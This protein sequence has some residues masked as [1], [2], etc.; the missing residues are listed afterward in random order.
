MLITFFSVCWILF[1]RFIHFIRFLFKKNPTVKYKIFIQKKI[2]CTDESF[3]VIATQYQRF[4]CPWLNGIKCGSDEVSNWFRFDVHFDSL[5]RGTNVIVCY[6]AW[7]RRHHEKSAIFA[8]TELIGFDLFDRGSGRCPLSR[9]RGIGRS[10]GY[11]W[12]SDW[13]TIQFNLKFK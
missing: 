4:V 8:W 12:H 10:I 13:A 11:T 9:W 1:I 5:T 7:A 2:I 6:T 3:N